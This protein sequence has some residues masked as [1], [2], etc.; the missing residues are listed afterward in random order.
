MLKRKRKFTIRQAAA[1][2]TKPFSP[3][4]VGVDKQN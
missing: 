2:T 3:K 4:Q 1:T